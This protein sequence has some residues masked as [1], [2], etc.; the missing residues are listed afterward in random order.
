MCEF[1]HLGNKPFSG[2]YTAKGK[3]K[4]GEELDKSVTRTL[5]VPYH[6][7]RN[8]FRQEVSESTSNNITWKY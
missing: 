8:I 6:R 7:F 2:R 5:E 1:V 3:I 4:N